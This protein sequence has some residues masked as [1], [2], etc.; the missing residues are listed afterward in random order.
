[1]SLTNHCGVLK[2]TASL[3]KLDLTL[4]LTMRLRS[5]GI[6]TV[7]ILT[8]MCACEVLDIPGVGWKSLGEIIDTLHDAE[9]SLNPKCRVQRD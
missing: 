9:L 3:D 7:G 8:D 2:R 6:G 1:M 4:E 5:R